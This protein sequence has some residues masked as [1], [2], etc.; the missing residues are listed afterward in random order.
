[1]VCHGSGKRMGSTQ[2]EELGEI[3][4]PVILTDTLSVPRA[5]ATLIDWTLMQPGNVD[6]QSL[7]PVLWAIEKA[8]S[9]PVVEGYAGPGTGALCF[10]CKGAIG[11]RSRLLSKIFGG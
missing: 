3:E 7:H 6:V 9:G 1:M 2:I 8:S 4:T 5:T 11:T 10:G